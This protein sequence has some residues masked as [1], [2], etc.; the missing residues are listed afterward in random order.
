MLTNYKRG[1]GI[2]DLHRKVLREA[3]I[4]SPL[5]HH[6]QGRVGLIDDRAVLDRIWPAGRNQ[7]KNAR[8]VHSANRIGGP[9]H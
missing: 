3:T 7:M 1:L 6:K 2:F 8:L 4:E 5:T 9:A